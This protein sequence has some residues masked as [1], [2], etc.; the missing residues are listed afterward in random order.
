M[1][2]IQNL[3]ELSYAI[4]ELQARQDFEWTMLK[5]QFRVTAEGLKPINII[6]GAFSEILS[7]PKLKSTVIN[8]VIG[9]TAGFFATKAFVR[10]T[11]NLLTRLILGSIAGLATASNGSKAVSGIKTMGNNI[12]RKLLR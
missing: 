12:L 3:E 1:E 7:A 2:K 6:K 9:L 5:E 8:S 4:Q 10:I 11:P